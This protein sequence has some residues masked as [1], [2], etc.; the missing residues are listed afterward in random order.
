MAYSAGVVKMRTFYL[1][2]G[3]KY[4]TQQEKQ[5]LKKLE[6]KKAIIR[7]FSAFNG[8]DYLIIILNTGKGGRCGRF[9]LE[10][11]L[12]MLRYFYSYMLMYG[13]AAF[14]DWEKVL[15]DYKQ[16]QGENHGWNQKSV[17]LLI[18]NYG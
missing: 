8:S 12:Q 11:L 16:H 2:R 13:W 1:K 3:L 10:V 14:R 7:L 15:L 4:E 18:V 5:M 9:L 6:A 17:S